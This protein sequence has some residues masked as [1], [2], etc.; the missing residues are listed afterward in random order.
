MTSRRQ[1]LPIVLV[2]ALATL[3]VAAP[4]LAADDVQ[5]FQLHF[6]VA[7]GGAINHEGTVTTLT[8]GAKVVV[9]D[10]TIRAERVEMMGPYLFCHGDVTVVNA[11]Q[12]M[13][14][15]GETMTLN[16]FTRMLLIRGSAILTVSGVPV[17][18]F[19]DDDTAKRIAIDLNRNVVRLDADIQETGSS[20]RA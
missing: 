20:T 14:I 7:S 4:A 15:G 5:G 19:Q 13:E 1:S 3:L 11:D 2:A 12:G 8:G 17:T 6:S 9:D 10:M 16:L 18:V